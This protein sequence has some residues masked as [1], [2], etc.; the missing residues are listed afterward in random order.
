M[1]IADAAWIT[2][3]RILA[4]SRTGLEL[5]AD[6]DSVD[7][8]TVFL[9]EIGQLLGRCRLRCY[10]R[11][12]SNLIRLRHLGRASRFFA[13]SS[14]ARRALLQRHYVAARPRRLARPRS[15]SANL[16]PAGSRSQR[17]ALNGPTEPVCRRSRPPHHS[18]PRSLWPAALTACCVPA[19]RGTRT[20]PTMKASRTRPIATSGSLVPR[21]IRAFW[22]PDASVAIM[23]R[24]SQI[25]A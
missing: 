19:P 1:L 4:R 11:D 10:R 14:N 24:I 13:S 5:L 3:A 7:A 22:P 2:L 6:F 15:E 21:S 16:P 20:N 18:S 17:S 8:Y 12:S 25:A 9:M 23:Q